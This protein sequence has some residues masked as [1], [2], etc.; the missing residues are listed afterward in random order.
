MNKTITAN[1]SGIV[2]HIESDAYEKLNRYLQTIRRYFEKSEGAE[3]IMS[4]IEARIA[5]LFKE[6]LKNEREVVTMEDVDSVITIMGEPEQ[7]MDSDSEDFD[8]GYSS[9]GQ[10][11][12]SK[13]LYRDT[14]DR[15]LGGVCSG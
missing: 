14:D 2:F 9:Y 5:E 10:K 4:D 1:I 15:V 3:E 8:T 13:K 7:Y 12:F 11:T 6:K